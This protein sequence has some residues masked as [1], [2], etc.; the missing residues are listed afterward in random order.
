MLAEQVCLLATEL[1]IDIKI[2]GEKECL[3][4][5]MGCYLGVQQGSMFPPQFIHAT[6]RPPNNEDSSSSSSSSIKHKVALIGKGLTFDS[7]G[8]N[9][10][11]GKGSM[12][13]QMKDDMGG[14]A[15]VFGAMKAIGQ[16]KPNNI[17]VHF[18]SAVCENM[19]SAQAIRPGDIL[20]AMNGK[21]VEVLD[22][23]AEG[24]LTLA[25]ALVYA[26]RLGVDTVIDLATL[27]GSIIAALGDKVAGLYTNNANL[28]TAIEQAAKRSNEK[29]WS[30]PM[31][32]SYKDT[33]KSKIADW[34]NIS[35]SRWGDS[36]MAALFLQEFIE[37]ATTNWA[38][39][40][41]AGPVTSNGQ[42][43]GYGV[44]L[45]VEYIMNLS[46]KSNGADR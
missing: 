22:T 38:H 13:E 4:L 8:Y 36:I 24:R 12:I 40:D 18:I 46:N 29:L 35:S 21:T 19:I 45:L 32:D 2:L 44:K 17:E 41:M 3:E 31:E 20:V 42:A 25:D 39:I 10:K 34:K 7:G 37:N 9:L 14:C 11:A 43:T 16:L 6:Y 5:G 28:Q 30:M 26:D 23:D 27:T 15:A 1:G 33:L